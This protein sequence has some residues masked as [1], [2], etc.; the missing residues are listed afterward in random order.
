MIMILGHLIF[1]ATE[2]V[3]CALQRVENNLQ[4]ILFAVDTLRRYLIRI[5]TD[6]YFRMFCERILAEDKLLPSEPFLPRIRKPPSRFIDFLP[7]SSSFETIY[8]LYRH[9]YMEVIDTIIDALDSRFKQSIFPLL[10]KVE[11]FILSSANGETDN[12]HSVIINDIDE[13]L[14]DD[15]SGERLERE[16]AML[17]DFLLTVN[18]E[19]DVGNQ[20]NNKNCYRMQTF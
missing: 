4:D 15:I 6:E 13:F 11:Q 19:K 8:D 17:L 14:T 16:Q 5:K 2:E 1:S 18:K 10:C 3:S 20:N 12:T 9:E 7:T